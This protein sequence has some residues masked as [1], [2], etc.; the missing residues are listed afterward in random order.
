MRKRAEMPVRRRGAKP[1]RAEALSEL[2]MVTVLLVTAV[3]V[4]LFAAG[5]PVL[6]VLGGL[7]AWAR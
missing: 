2:P 4:A 3:L 6:E 7:D 5:G 1:P